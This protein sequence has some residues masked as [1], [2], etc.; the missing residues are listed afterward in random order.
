MTGDGD[1]RDFLGGECAG[2]RLLL[3]KGDLDLGPLS[4]EGEG[5]VLCLYLLS[6]L[7]SL[8]PLV[9]GDLDR[10]CLWDLLFS[11]DLMK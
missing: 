2:E 7:F 3:F 1:F 6:S 4:F 11:G 10:A 5:D 9:D 8:S